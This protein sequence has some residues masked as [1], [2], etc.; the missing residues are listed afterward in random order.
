MELNAHPMNGRHSC[1][2]FSG[3]KVGEDLLYKLLTYYDDIEA[4]ALT[5]H[6]KTA[7]KFFDGS[8]WEKLKDHVGYNGF[9]IKAPMY[10]VIYSDEKGRYLENAGY[11]GEAMTLKM[12]ELGLATC[13]QTVNH[14]EETKKELGRETDMVVA[15]VVAFG[16]RSP[17]DKEKAV[18]KISV[19]DLTFGKVY[20]QD[21][22]PSLFYPEL[23]AGLKAMANAQSFLNRQP[24]RVIVDDDQI[25]LVGLYDEITK[26]VDMHLNYGIVM[27]DY[28]NVA[29][30]TRDVYTKWSFAP[31]TDR[32]LKLPPDVKY[33]SKCKL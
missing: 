11:L 5:L 20:G 30:R 21:I 4:S 28:I 13:W 31:V 16:Y 24:Y 18:P 9:C 27:Y 23:A 25:V 10:M 17:K 1:R 32:D 3:K 33:I 12:T 22:D 14:P 7:M 2:L 15:C 8:V 29:A 19:D 26:E 6:I